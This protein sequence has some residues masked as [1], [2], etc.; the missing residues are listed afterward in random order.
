MGTTDGPVHHTIVLSKIAE[1]PAI[2][3]LVALAELALH[4]RLTSSV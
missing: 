4:A 3:P 2:W 1:S